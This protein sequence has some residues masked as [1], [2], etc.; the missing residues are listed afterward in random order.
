MELRHY[1]Q[2]LR[3]WAWL[4][5]LVV[6]LAAGSSYYYSRTIAPSYRAD[7]TLLV[8]QLQQNAS[9][10]PSGVDVATNLA[11]AY[12]LLATQPPVLQAAADALNFP[13]GW[14]ALYFHVQGSASGNQLIKISGTSNDPQLAAQIANEIARQII[15]QSPISAQQKQSEDQRAFVSG[16]QAILRTQIET[17]QKTLANLDNQQAL[18]ND[19]AKLQDLN[20]RIFALQTKIDEWQKNYVSLSAL[21]NTDSGRFLTVLAAAQ[22]PTTPVSPN[23]LQNVLFAALA[24]LVLAGGAILLLEYLDDTIKSPADIESALAEVNIGSGSRSTLGTITRISNIH[25][26][27]DLL[28]ASKHPRSPITEA[29][30]A[31]RTN[32]RFSGVD[33]TNMALLVSSAGPGEG[34]TTTSTNLAVV[35]AQGGKRVVIVDADLRRP[36]LHKFFDLPNN[37]GLSSLFLDNPPPLDQV[38]QQ[39]SIQGLRVLTSGAIPPNPAELLDSRKMTDLISQLRAESDLVIFDSPPVLAVADASIIGSH[40]TGALLVVDAGKTRT[41]LCRHAFETLAKN[42]VKILGVVLNKVSARRGSGYYYY[43]YYS[44]REPK[45]NATNGKNGSGAKQV[46]DVI[47]PPTP[48]APTTTTELRKN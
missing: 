24:G 33:A 13:D 6:A 10:D 35:F 48:P 41:E 29:Y 8:G 1:F 2:L 31:L 34:K 3:K 42:N 9:P 47:T 38:I 17:G 16:Q 11:Q 30:R 25:K 45:V 15:L 14:Q 46:P 19:P 26:Q 20:G 21:L 28:I 12:S 23:I 44:S 32:L 7:T 36:S 18:E 5:V 40:C 43:P 22:A 27:A 39:T 4:V 37:V